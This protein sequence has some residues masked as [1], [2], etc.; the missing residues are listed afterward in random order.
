M[1]MDASKA[2]MGELPHETTSLCPECMKPL[3]ALVYAKDGIVWIKKTCPD[4][5][6]FKEKY[7]E[8]VDMYNKARKHGAPPVYQK[9]PNVDTGGANCPFDCGLCTRHKSHTMLAN[10]VATN[11]CDL[12]CWYCFFYAKEGQPIYEPSLD[13]I[14][15]MIKNLVSEQPVPCNAVQ[16]TGGEPTLREDLIEM[17]KIIKEEGVDHVQINTDAINFAFKPELVKGLREAG[18][19]TVYMSFDGITPKTNPKN[20]WEAPYAI[21]NCRKAGMG[22]V[23]VPTVIKGVNDQELGDIINFGLNNSDIIRGVNF[24]PVSLVGRMPQSLR[25]QQRITIPKAIDNI[26][27]QTKGLITKDDFFPVPCVHPISHLVEALKGRKTYDLSTHFACGMATYVIKGNDDVPVPITQF[28]DVEGLFEYLDEKADDIKNSRFKKLKAA[29]ILFKLGS[30]VDRE[31]QPKGFDFKKLMFGAV[32]KHDYRALGEIM[33]RSLMIGMMHFQ[34][35]YNYDV[36]RV[37]R[38]GIHYT[39]PDGRIIP[40]CAFNVIPE[41]YRDKVQ[42]QYSIPAEEWEKANNTTILEGKYVRDAE[43]LEQGDAYKKAYTLKDYFK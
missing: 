38:C 35:P 9:N 1:Q 43:K 37:E 18:S 30:F 42:A 17:V 16:I 20:H 8:S 5:G 26:E 33:H 39:M 29:G 27:Q 32:V 3:G 15:S 25:E 21:E 12:S 40:F 7:W 36:E 34:D 31:K 24:Q 23:L 2:Y 19:N 10:I 11:R 6:E 14:R 13:Q 22:I 28:V 41:V 4:H